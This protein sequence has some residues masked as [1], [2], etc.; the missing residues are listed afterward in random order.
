M[1]EYYR[2]QYY[3]DLVYSLPY[4]LAGLV[5]TLL[6]LYYS[7]VSDRRRYTAFAVHHRLH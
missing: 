6:R 2:R 5:I 3:Y 1:G 4:F 7:G